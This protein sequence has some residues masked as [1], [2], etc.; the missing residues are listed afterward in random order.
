MNDKII[1]EFVELASKSY[2]FK[3]FGSNTDLKKTKGIK[4][5]YNQESD[6]SQ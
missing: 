4:K 3:I 1:E 2:S 6:H 5:T